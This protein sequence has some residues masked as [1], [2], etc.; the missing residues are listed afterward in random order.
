MPE[1]AGF[2]FQ[3]IAVQDAFYPCKA[4]ADKHPATHPAADIEGIE[5]WKF[6]PESSSDKNRSLIMKPL[7]ND[8]DRTYFIGMEA[9][10]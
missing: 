5:A 6:H 4:F 9:S 10:P 3:Q 8:K 1:I 2:W 7:R